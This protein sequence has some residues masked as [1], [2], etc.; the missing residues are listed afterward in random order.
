MKKDFDPGAQDLTE[1]TADTMPLGCPFRIAVSWDAGRV[2][3]G[4]DVTEA[5]NLRR[6]VQAITTAVG[7]SPQS[8]QSTE[9]MLEAFEVIPFP[10]ESKT[11]ADVSGSVPVLQANRMR[12]VVMA[13]ERNT[14][15]IVVEFIERIVVR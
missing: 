8:G 7:R 1:I 13:D 6:L 11:L 5:R 14:P 10:E 3:L 9:F 4:D 2:L 12:A 15:V